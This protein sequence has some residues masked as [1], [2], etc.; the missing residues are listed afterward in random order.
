MISNLVES[1]LAEFERPL[2]W[3][4]TQEQAEYERCLQEVLAENGVA[5]A[6]GSI[7]VGDYILIIDS[8]TRVPS[9]CLLDAVSEM[10]QSPEV[11]I[12]QF[13]SGVMQVVNDFFED[14]IVSLASMQCV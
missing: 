13:S 1:K 4:Q 5:W 7:R 3:T 14:G 6:D 2:Q 12:M 11:G 8:D 9:D 10:E